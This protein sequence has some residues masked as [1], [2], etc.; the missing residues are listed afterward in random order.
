ML[1][2]W[3]CGYIRRGLVPHYDLSDEVRS[4]ETGLRVQEYPFRVRCG[5]L[6]KLITDGCVSTTTIRSPVDNSKLRMRHTTGR[7]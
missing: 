7:F 3:D 4:A 1:D 5:Q 6:E 2:L